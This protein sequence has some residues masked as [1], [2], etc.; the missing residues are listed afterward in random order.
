MS[1]TLDLHDDR[2]WL[3]V[4]PLDHDLARLVPGLTFNHK[5][6]VWSGLPSWGTALACRGVFG[7]ELAMTPAVRAWAEERVRWER[8]VEALKVW[9][10]GAS[11]AWTEGLYPPQVSGAGYLA[12]MARGAITD[13]AG[14]GKGVMVAVALGLLKPDAFPALIVCPRTV[15]WTHARHLEE[16][17][18]HLHP[19]VVSGS[20]AKRRKLIEE[21]LTSEGGVLIMNWESLRYHSKL[22]PYGS[23]ARSEKEKEPGELNVHIPTVI[24]DEAHRAKDPRSKQT[25][26][27]WAVSHEAD[28][29]WVTTATPIPDPIGFWS[30]MHTVAPLDFQSRVK[31]QDRYCLTEAIFAGGGRKVEKVRAFNPRTEAELRRIAEPYMLR[32]TLDQIVGAG[33]LPP[34]VP[35]TLWVEME[36]KQETAYKA[37]K[38]DMLAKVPSGIIAATDP[39]QQSLRLLQ[40]ASALPTFDQENRL[41]S[42]EEPSSKL[43]A[44]VDWLEDHDPALSLVVFAVSRRLIELCARKLEHLGIPYGL[45]TGAQNEGARRMAEDGFQRKDLRV[46]LGTYGAM[47]EGITLTAAH[48]QLM[49]QRSFKLIENVQAD[50]RCRRIGQDADYVNIIDVVSVNSYD[51]SVFRSGAYKEETA[52]AILQD[53]DWIKRE[54]QRY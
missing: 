42:F 36:G 48:H 16:W 8:W 24:A 22:A 1:A 38:K 41:V 21:G 54:L 45:I 10:P 11:P 29:V 6:N 15:K 50:G 47:S 43:N 30:I 25:R 34:V 32:R 2:L 52:Q 53:P 3:E 4:G 35:S 14:S 27:L 40:M 7:H 46:L 44:L 9:Q 23:T 13:E 18:P 33:G 19:V 51:E 17:A 28:R 39:M 31:F 5:T 20:A 37:M 26:A 49:L 12:A